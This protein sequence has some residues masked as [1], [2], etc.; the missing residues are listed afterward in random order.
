MGQ[1]WL[2]HYYDKID[3]S[4]SSLSNVFESY[5]I[6]TQYSRQTYK[7]KYTCKLLSRSKIV[8][9][10]INYKALLCHYIHRIQIIYIE[11]Y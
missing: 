8:K 3:L 2:V 7:C 6:F 1:P 10:Q 5:D 11:V 4:K 9:I